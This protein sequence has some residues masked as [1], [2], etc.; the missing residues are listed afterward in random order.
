MPL[1][2]RS[3][4]GRP[5]GGGWLYRFTGHGQHGLTQRQKQKGTGMPSA[6]SPV[7]NLFPQAALLGLAMR[8][9]VRRGQLSTTVKRLPRNSVSLGESW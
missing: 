5:Q 1:T 4:L 6:T 3:V 2:A 9:S 8:L 7:Q